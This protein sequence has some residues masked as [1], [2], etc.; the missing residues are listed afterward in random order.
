MA[1][2]C[3]RFCWQELSVDLNNLDSGPLNAMLTQPESYET[4]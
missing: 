1:T 3:E 4:K 2:E